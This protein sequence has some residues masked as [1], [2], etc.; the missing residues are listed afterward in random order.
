MRSPRRSLIGSYRYSVVIKPDKAEYS[1]S[2]SGNLDLYDG[3][4]VE[5]THK[6]TSFDQLATI[7][8]N[9]WEK[10]L[11]NDVNIHRFSN[12][13]SEYFS[14]IGVTNIDFYQML[15]TVR[16]LGKGVVLQSSGVA[17]RESK[18]IHEYLG[19]KK[20]KPTKEVDL[21]PAGTFVD[22]RGEGMEPE[23]AKLRPEEPPTDTVLKP[24]EIF[25][26]EETVSPVVT[27]IPV[28]KEEE[29]E[30][31]EPPVN[32]LLKPSEVLKERDSVV[33]IEDEPRMKAQ[34]SGDPVVTK[35]QEKTVKKTP[36]SDT[37]LK[38]SEYLKQREIIDVIFKTPAEPTMIPEEKKTEFSVDVEKLESSSD[39]L[40]RPSEY[41]KEME[42]E[43]DSDD[44]E[45]PLEKVDK[46]SV[47]KSPTATI[48]P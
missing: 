16:E 20:V 37:L 14:D 18:V 12:W 26:T 1:S 17:I 22:V 11:G 35:P 32:T 28:Q 45:K 7:I 33:F 36:P 5:E 6:F 27:H 46:E 42:I 15:E 4:H 23:A 8:M 30:K 13:L 40:L 31:P 10:K 43:A 21:K 38:P 9:F 41:L 44:I 19:D 48:D 34:V 3:K 29:E 39:K 24:S 47:V 2:M 25:K